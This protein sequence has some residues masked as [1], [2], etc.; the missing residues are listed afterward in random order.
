[1]TYIYLKKVDL[2]L[3]KIRI[4]HFIHRTQGYLDVK[5]RLDYRRHG[6]RS[7]HSF[8]RK[9]SSYQNMMNIHGTY[10]YT[11]GYFFGESIGDERKIER[12]LYKYRN[13]FLSPY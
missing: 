13:D 8:P 1:M 11:S 9:T 3:L 5:S 10:V 2:S 7:Y 6:L 4:W 12:K